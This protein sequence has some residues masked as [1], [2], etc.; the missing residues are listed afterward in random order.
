VWHAETRSLRESGKLKV[1]GIVEEQH[2]DRARLFLQ[3]KGVDWPI[4][5]DPLNLLGVSAVPLTFLVDEH[6]I[7]RGTKVTRDT[8]EDFVS[9]EYEGPDEKARPDDADVSPEAADTKALLARAD[10]LFARG[11]KGTDLDAAIETYA[12]AVSLGGSPEASFRLGVALRSRHDS[13]R[14]RPGDFQAAVDAWAAA[15]RERPGQ[16]IWR[17]RI[18]QYGPRL[19]K[20]YAFY[21]W[22]AEARSEIERRGEKPS[23]LAIEPRGSELAEPLKELA[24]SATDVEDPDPRGLLPRDEKALVLVE[25]TVVPP[26]VEPG[27]A[28]RV[29]VSLRP[30]PSKDAH[31]NNEAGPLVLLVEPP[32]GTTLESAR[33]EAPPGR[34]ELSAE[35]RLLDFEVR[36]PR[37]AKESKVELRAHACY[38]VCEGASGVCYY[39]RRDLRIAV[40]V[41][42][43]EAKGASR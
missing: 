12:K 42:T 27:K 19:E 26:S 9:A 14:R 39:L 20:P 7:V 41:A 5:V 36:I 34:G 37:D 30:D 35:E 23:P 31:W 25:T 1:V 29:H 22:I 3:W 17:R 32:P 38:F 16:Y 28:A 11:K 21:D 2:P 18:Q 43:G 10:A 33:L 15:L 24:P 40:P 13:P 6:G 4:L 8:L